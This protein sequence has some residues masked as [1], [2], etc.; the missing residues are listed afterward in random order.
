MAGLFLPLAFGA[1]GVVTYK[2]LLALHPKWSVTTMQLGGSLRVADVQV[3]TI[4][5]TLA[6]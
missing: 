1:N 4:G 3:V 6:V 5:L 2:V